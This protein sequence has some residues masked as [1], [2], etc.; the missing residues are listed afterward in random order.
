MIIRGL[1]VNYGNISD[2]SANR[3]WHLRHQL[4]LNIK[5]R[6]GN[7]SEEQL[8]AELMTIEIKRKQKVE[9]INLSADVKVKQL[10]D[11]SNKAA[12]LWRDTHGK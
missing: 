10:M 2:W 12:A 8:L 7:T 4:R 6:I 5:S 3:L 11:K 9:K 1:E